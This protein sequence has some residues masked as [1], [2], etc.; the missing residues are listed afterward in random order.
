[1]PRALT[2]VLL[3]SSLAAPAAA[4]VGAACFASQSIDPGYAAE[5]CRQATQDLQAAIMEVQAKQKAAASS[6]DPAFAGAVTAQ[7]RALI[8]DYWRLVTAQQTLKGQLQDRLNHID[9]NQDPSQAAALKNAIGALASARAEAAGAAWGTGFL[10]KEMLAKPKPG[11][12]KPLQQGTGTAAGGSGTATTASGASDQVKSGVG[13][14]LSEALDTFDGGLTG[15]ERPPASSADNGAPAGA[16]PQTPSPEMGRLAQQEQSLGPDASPQQLAEVAAGYA[17]AG[18]P[19]D[20]QRLYRRAVE[21]RPEADSYARLAQAEMQVG[22]TRAALDHARLARSMDPRNALA[23]LI[24]GHG[25]AL[26]RVAPKAAGF[27]AS[28]AQPDTGPAAAGAPGFG[29]AARPQAAAAAGPAA[30]AAPQGGAPASPLLQKAWSK[31]ALGD[32]TGALLLA[33]QAIE[34][35]PKDARGWALRAEILG[36]LKSYEAAVKDAAQALA[37]DPVNAQALRAKAYAELQLGRLDEALADADRAVRVEPGSA[38]GHLYR[39][40][41][42]EKLGRAAEALAE[43]DRAAGLDASL[44]P[45][46]AEARGRLGGAAAPAAARAPRLPLADPRLVRYGLMLAALA[47]ILAG[48]LGTR[49][50][51]E[52][53]EG[54]RRALAGRGGEAATLV[55]EGRELSEG[56]L[57]GGQYRVTRELGRGGMGVVY[58]AQ[59]ETLR[60][61]VALK[62][63]QGASP[64]DTERFLREARLVAQLKHPRVAEIHN[65]VLEREP[66]LVFELVE[67]RPLSAVLAEKRRLTPEEARA[68]VAQVCEALEYAH[69]RQ[70]IHRDLKPSNVMVGQDS[71]LKVMDFGIAHQASGAATATR[72]AASGTPAYMAPEQ[73]LGSVSK[74][75]DLYALGV[76]AYELLTGAR[77]FPGPDF[78]EQKLQQ[79][80]EPAAR[81]AP[82]LPAGAD[83][84]FARAL[85]ADPTKRFSSAAE[86]RAAF[87]ALFAAASA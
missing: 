85:A 73:A 32:L 72:T 28:G 59:D 84:F 25:D 71:G 50:G 36:R 27:G 46:A 66:I 7:K 75:S 37:L 76:M 68:V 4:G 10:T 26:S 70:I 14:A 47:L 61:R 24:L 31:A 3:A 11:P 77:P 42:L 23:N 6:G 67:G 38:L 49:A 35:A 52:I 53:T 29:T 15:A 20:A 80:F 8:A 60:R 19:W 13:G 40:M 33:S 41:I 86:L 22:D 2:A 1:M 45:L 83:A 21:S 34:A 62:R 12:S 48:L 57:V 51:R 74:A 56:S 81:L 43:F 16:G 78:L 9:Q 69:G 82:G 30:G 39:A 44:A 79:R 65:V 54:A 18:E 58:E 63:M 5:V 55:D 64:E 17:R 87:D